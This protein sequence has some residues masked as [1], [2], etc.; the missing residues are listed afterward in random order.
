MKLQDWEC[1]ASK[2][3]VD[4]RGPWEYPKNPSHCQDY[5]GCCPQNGSK[6]PLLKTALIQVFEHEDVELV[7]T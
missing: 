2:R 3:V 4:Q 5:I 1:V 6:M 7:P